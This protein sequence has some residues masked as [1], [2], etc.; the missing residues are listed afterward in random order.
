MN[1]P[2]CGTTNSEDAIFCIMCGEKVS[3]I[4]PASKTASA[5]GAEDVTAPAKIPAAPVFAGPAVHMPY[6]MPLPP[7][8]LQERRGDKSKNW[9]AICSLVCGIVSVPMMITA[10]GGLFTGVLLAVSRILGETAPLMLTTLGASMV[11]W[12]I[13]KPTSSIPLLIWEFYN[14]PNLVDL[15]WSSSL[16]LLLIILTLNL[17]AK[18]IARRWKIQ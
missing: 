15:I 2:K 8:Q 5:A 17:T 16:L 1:C 12:D 7:M 18:N 10:F 13:Q 4:E 11:N 3:P 6:A 9:Q 14:D